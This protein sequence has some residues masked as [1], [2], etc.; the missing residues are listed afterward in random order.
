MRAWMRVLALFAV[1]ATTAAP[2]AAQIPQRFENLQILP[3]EIARDSLISIMRG[4]SLSLGV[5]CVHCHVGEDNPGLVGIDFKSDDR[6]PTRVAR[7]MLRMVATVNDDLLARVRT[8]NASSTSGTRVTCVTCHRGMPRPVLIEDTLQRVLERHGTD[9]TIAEY[10]RLRA[11]H[12]GRGRLDFGIGALNALTERLL[13]QERYADA[14]TLAAFNAELF[15]DRWEAA[16]TLGRA[17]E[18]LAD[19]TAAVAQ[20]RRVLEAVPNL[21]PARQRLDRLTRRP[22]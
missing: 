13:A 12:F 14:R 15:P 18:G 7:E 4:F 5:R 22:P 3:K 9:S 1:S 2:V 11:E 16:Y 6:A 21:A 20:Y 17:H 8:I 19:T 10:R